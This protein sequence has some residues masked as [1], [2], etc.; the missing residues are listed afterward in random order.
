MQHMDGSAARL[1]VASGLLHLFGDR[2]LIVQ[3]RS[4]GY[5][6]EPVPMEVSRTHCPN[7]Q[8]R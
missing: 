6:V 8:L 7:P 1:V 4:L 2:G 5:V 3:L